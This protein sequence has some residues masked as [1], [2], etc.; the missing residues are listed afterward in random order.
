ML[1]RCV[2]RPSPHAAVGFASFAR[3][4]FKPIGATRVRRGVPTAPAD[5]I[6]PAVT[7]SHPRVP[8]GD[9][10]LAR[11]AESLAPRPTTRSTLFHIDTDI[12]YRT[13]RQAHAELRPAGSHRRRQQ[14]QPAVSSR[15]SRRV[16]RRAVRTRRGRRG[17]GGSEGKQTPAA[18]T[19]TVARRR[20]GSTFT[21]GRRA[22]TR[23][24]PRASEA[25][26][27]DGTRR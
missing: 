6:G 23:G 1:Y 21:S 4:F 20:E 5:R 12:P 24:D 10:R 13:H 3:V 26:S 2:R 16:N 19:V 22:T 9:P 14:G 17:W 27:V 7:S 15:A 8:L 18:A 25:G 11:R